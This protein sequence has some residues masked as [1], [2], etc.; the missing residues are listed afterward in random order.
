MMYKNPTYDE[1]WAEDIQDDDWPPK[2]TYVS[3]DDKMSNF[4][5]GVLSD[6]P[7]GAS[8]FTCPN[9]GGTAYRRVEK[10]FF[11]AKCE[12]CGISLMT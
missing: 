6:A 7:K 12:N 11:A 8:S 1:M 3:E 5:R 9:C 2:E 10:G 4:I